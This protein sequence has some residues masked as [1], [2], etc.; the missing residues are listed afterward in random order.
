MPESRRKVYELRCA[1]EVPEDWAFLCDI[2]K[3]LTETGVGGALVSSFLDVGSAEST[4]INLLSNIPQASDIIPDVSKLYDSFK[5]DLIALILRA[6]DIDVPVCSSHHDRECL[7]VNVKMLPKKKPW[8]FTAE[9][10]Y[11]DA[12]GN[13]IVVYT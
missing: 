2:R 5:H 6:V 10:V 9:L 11:V 12:E 13:Y 1:P 3:K 7:T 8:F 4:T